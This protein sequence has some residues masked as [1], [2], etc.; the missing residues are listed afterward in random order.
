MRD[1]DIFT[2]I[3]KV[4]GP[5]DVGCSDNLKTVRFGPAQF[6]NRIFVSGE[7]PTAQAAKHNAAGKALKML[8]EMPIPDGKSK[9]DPTSQPF[10]PGIEYDDLKSPISLGTVLISCGMKYNG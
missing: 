4:S 2:I 10:T 7:G 5:G 8:K 1:S 6:Y 3:Y 9:L